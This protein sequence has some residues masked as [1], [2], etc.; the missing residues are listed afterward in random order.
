VISAA[1][2]KQFLHSFEIQRRVTGALI[3][4]EII[5]RYGRHNIGFLWLF[6][7]PMIFT[8]GVAT[9][10][11]LIRSHA[12]KDFPIFAFA[13]TGYSSILLWRNIVNRCAGAIAPNISLMHHRNVREIDIYVS[14][15]ILE[16]A[17]A[18]ISFVTLSVI[19]LV[20]GYISSPDD[21]LKVC[22]GWALLAWFGASLGLTLGSL[23]ER[24]ELVEKIWHPVS[25]LMF[26]LSGAAF[27]VDWL[28][29]IGQEIVLYFP[30][31]HGLELLRH[32][33]FG[34]TFNYHYSVAYIIV[35]CMCLTFIGL[36]LVATSRKS[37]EG[38]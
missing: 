38:K 9:L 19:F 25:Y 6:I 29:K 35:C 4:R 13:T 15:I 18:T 20:L 16:I 22:F 27:M 37:G 2:V 11:S 3:L 28:P 30:M 1:S 21:L 17:G 33:Y 14:R 32:G 5:T 26:P 34:G 12:H 7:E 24:S 10:W 8:V 31:V 23:S 36:S